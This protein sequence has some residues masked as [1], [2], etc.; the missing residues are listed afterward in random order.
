MAYQ[1]RH[2]KPAGE[3]TYS[4]PG[5]LFLLGEYAV[6]EGAPALLAAVDRRAR[7][8]ARPAQAW[9][10]HTRPALSNA[11]MG[12][13]AVFV[14]VRSAVV[15]RGDLPPQDVVIATEDFFGAGGKLGLGASAAVAA[16]LT[17]AL[18]DAAGLRYTTAE[19]RDLA[20]AAHRE[21]QGGAGSGADVAVAVHGG[22]IA[23]AAGGAPEPL[24]W[25]EG[26]HAAA[27]VTG[28]GADTRRLVGTVRALAVADPERYRAV[29]RPLEEAAARGRDAWA[30]GDAAGFLGVADAYR[31]SL[32]ALGEAAGAGIVLPAHERLAALAAGA[33]AVFKPSGAGGGDLGLLFADSATA[34]ARAREAVTGAGFEVPDLGFGT[35]GLAAGSEAGTGLGVK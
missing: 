5:K 27:V 12:G 22:V 26:L 33:G 11:G 19:L 18:A 16:A 3:V 13:R 24:A 34:L 9:H 7:V 4:A 20:I 14:A 35:V 32:A 15:A 31:G 29:M 1:T 6:L 23:F 28:S 21:A 25:P 17:G 30:A 2:P 10:L 8:R